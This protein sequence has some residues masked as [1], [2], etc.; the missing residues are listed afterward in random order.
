MMG[1]SLLPQVEDLVEAEVRHDF[2]AKVTAC[3]DGENLA[4][5][6]HH[7]VHAAVGAVEENIRRRSYQ[8]AT[9][10]QVFVSEIG[11]LNL[12]LFDGETLIHVHELVLETFQQRPH[13]LTR[14]T[15][16][17]NGHFYQFE[18]R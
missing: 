10:G 9:Y 14:E 16:I 13:L 4:R 6:V 3:I 5:D 8:P 11:N 15:A 7:H 12:A 17:D 18:H 2:A 1:V